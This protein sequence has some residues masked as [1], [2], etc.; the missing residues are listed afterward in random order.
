[1][2]L[3]EII[4]DGFSILCDEIKKHYV[5]WHLHKDD[6]ERKKIPIKKIILCGSESNINGLTEYLSVAMRHK[7]ELANVWTNVLNTEKLIP[8]ISF[9]ESFNFAGALGMALN[10]FNKGRN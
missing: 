3:S 2:K 4:S 1:M 5:Y 6:G 8:E 9:E 7:V 10:G